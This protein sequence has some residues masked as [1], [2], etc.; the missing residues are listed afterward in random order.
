MFWNE[1]MSVRNGKQGR[2]LY[3]IIEYYYCL[4]III[5]LQNSEV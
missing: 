2:M 5:T 4:I 3:L 1:E